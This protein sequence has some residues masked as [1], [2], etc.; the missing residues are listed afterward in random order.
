[1]FHYLARYDV[2]RP[3]VDVRCPACNHEQGILRGAWESPRWSTQCAQ[4]GATYGV[5]PEHFFR[6]F[7]SS[8]WR[9]GAPG[10]AVYVDFIVRIPA[11][12][13]TE[14]RRWHGWVDSAT[15]EIVQEG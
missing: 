5:G 3:T 2:A 7:V 10:T 13:G 12:T 1:M 8:R 4:C 6:M 9:K 14:E 15:R 11:T